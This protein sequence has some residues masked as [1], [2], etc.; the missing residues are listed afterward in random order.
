MN[1]QSETRVAAAAADERIEADPFVADVSRLLLTF[2]CVAAIDVVVVSLFTHRLRFW[3]PL[4]L[5]PDW[6][7]RPDPWV[8]YSQSYFAGIFMIPFLCRIIDRDFLA[9][10]AAAA[11]AVFWSLSAVIFVFVL[12]W[13]GALMLQYHK[14]VEILG[15]AA[16]TG[17]VWATIRMIGI[18]PPWVRGLSRKRMLG[19]LSF[20]LALFFLAMSVID[21]FIQLGV[22][23]LSWSVGLAIEIGFFVPAGVILM[24]ASRLFSA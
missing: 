4:W 21:P 22:Q 16:L 3:F 18:L 23:R 5:D 15:W 2:V 20:S 10:S 19:A 8:V 6:D 12:W 1:V 14:Q 13:K 7:A 9:G 11:R 24:I 17:A